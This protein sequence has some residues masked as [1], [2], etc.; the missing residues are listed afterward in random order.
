M[1][2]SLVVHW[3]AHPISSEPSGQLASPRVRVRV[4][5][6]I[7]ATVRVRVRVGV[8]VKVRM[9]V[10]GRLGAVGRAVAR[11]ALVDALAVGALDAAAAV[12]QHAPARGAG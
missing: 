3:K 2:S 9:R 12:G 5:V 4:R 1:M 6:R 8:G 7:R 11:V 10:R